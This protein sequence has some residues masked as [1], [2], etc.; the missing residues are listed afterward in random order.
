MAPI[1]DPGQIFTLTFPAAN[2]ASSKA[3]P[4]N[5]VHQ[6]VHI[7]QLTANMQS[8]SGFKLPATG[9]TSAYRTWWIH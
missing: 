7:P 8:N 3:D 6:H 4:P 9:N 1:V 5:G 2:W